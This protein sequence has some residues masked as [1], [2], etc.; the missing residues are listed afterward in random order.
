MGSVLAI[1]SK[2]VFEKM[3][4]APKLGDRISV[5]R[6]NSK[7]KALTPLEEGGALFMVTVRPPEEQLWLVA[8]LESPSFDGACWSAAA[9]ELPLTDVSELR[10]KLKFTSGKGIT[11]K[12][13]ALGMSLQTPR[14]LT[15]DDEALLR[16][17]LSSE[18]SAR[19]APAKRST[20]EPSSATNRPPKKTK[21]KKPSTKQP[22]PAKPAQ[23]APA[24]GSSLD[25]AL[26]EARVALEHADRV[27]A[28]DALL[29]A[30]RQCRAPQ[31]AKLIEVVSKDADRSLPEVSAGEAG[32]FDA[33]WRA[34][35]DLKRAVDIERLVPGMWGD[36]RGGIPMRVK[37]L[38]DRG[39]DP[40][41]GAG[42]LRMIETPPTTASS[43]FS[44]WSNVF[45]A[46]P[47]YVDDS[48]APLLEKRAAVHDGKSNFWPKLTAWING[49]VP[50]LPAP[51]KLTKA[52]ATAARALLARARELSKLPAQQVEHSPQPTTTWD[53]D[54]ADLGRAAAALQEED[55][56]SALQTLRFF[57]R[58]TRS[59]EAAE[60]IDS[61]SHRL[62]LSQ[63]VEAENKSAAAKLWEELGTR[64][65][66][67]EEI[68]PL[69]VTLTTGSMPQQEERL[70]RMLGWTP[71]PRVA[72]RMVA[73]CEDYMIGARQTFWQAVFDLLV[74]N[75][76]PRSA[77][78]VRA[79]QNR[80]GALH[81]HA[82]EGR[83][84]RRT[85]EAFEEA[86][87]R[88]RAITA[89]ERSRLDSIRA[90]LNELSQQGSGR[91]E[92]ELA[93]EARLLEAI[94]QDPSDAP[95]L[96]YSDWL[97]ERG[98]VRGELIQLMVELSRGKKIKR[99]VDR[100][101]REH[102][103]VILGP[104][105]PICRGWELDRGVLAK[106]R[107]DTAKGHLRQSA[108]KL[109]E[110]YRDLR[111]STV[112][113]IGVQFGELPAEW[114][115][116]APLYALTELHRVSLADVARL[117]QREDAHLIPVQQISWVQ[118]DDS[119]APIEALSRVPAGALPELWWLELS[120]WESTRR[121]VPALG[122]FQTAFAK[123]LKRL[124][125]GG[126]STGGDLR[127]R[128][129]L[130]RAAEARCAVELE[131]IGPEHAMLLT[132]ETPPSRKAAKSVPPRWHLELKVT[133]APPRFDE[134]TYLH[135]L[136]ELPSELIASKQVSFAEGLEPKLHN[137]VRKA[138]A[139]LG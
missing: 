115:S 44:V 105:E 111:W 41:V 117:G 51:A 99:K 60:V 18:R 109:N 89:A 130:E 16:R 125:N 136:A 31:L 87:S 96:V 47:S 88:G 65:P 80:G 83:H 91:R 97:L 55:L 25:G 36:P 8:V 79:R 134:V 112:R 128:D 49:A 129:W 120:G 67:A 45:K 40:R 101:Q 13:G 22:A 122:F 9:S 113:D 52:R 86:L 1:V 35:F 108:D 133:R 98:D 20:R 138:V 27:R 59:S 84:A 121:A 34:T 100:F 76:D 58:E 3:A 74:L 69:L 21:T 33:A 124:V 53:P 4:R 68:G 92:R 23:V 82:M 37:L 135:T 94:R 15:A 116:Q 28:L 119:S 137:Q 123:R 19:P 114:F 95:R 2:V 71:D 61:L 126:G 102:Q 63:Q 17:A 7:H 64:D 93:A 43:N 5:D 56:A 12:P 131:L 73:L 78:F 90:S 11:A 106:L 38:L 132:P 118:F 24:T 75:A 70:L 10:S 57:W 139:H 104:L 62:S 66:G 26:E 39:P 42:M 30:W 6:Y 72:R 48:A 32:D 46:L 14:E 85:A 103:S 107:V 29:S 110:L 81:R 127:A 77:D 54:A 50:K